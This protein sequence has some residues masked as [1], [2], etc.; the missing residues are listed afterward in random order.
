M[1]DESLVNLGDLSKPATALIKKVSD[2]VGG[3]FRPF[4]IVRVAK[5]EA[6]AERVRAEM[7]IEII[8]LHRRAMYRFLEEEAKR[9]SNIESI[10]SQALPL[11]NGEATPEKVENDWITNFFD[12]GRIVSDTDMQRLW[13]SVLAGE[14]NS[15]GTFAKR[16][17]NLLGDLERRDAELLTSICRFGWILDVF[18][19]LIFDCNLDL[20]VRLGITFGS[21][22]H[23]ESLGLLSFESMGLVRKKLPRT[24]ESRY[25]DKTLTLT[26]RKDE[27]NT[28]EVGQVM[29]SRAGYQLAL[30]CELAPVEGF[31]ETVQDQWAEMGLAPKRD[32]G[33]TSEASS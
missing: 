27:D 24:I 29:L 5:A 22:R 21:L 13:A 33:P 25:F 2:A 28:L 4:Q 26:F 9:Q 15:P 11:L 16:T 31:F 23:L 19:P 20:Y 12:K 8:D 32:S 1:P 14:A 17:V 3:I 7:R 6:E 18:T 30:L 10:T